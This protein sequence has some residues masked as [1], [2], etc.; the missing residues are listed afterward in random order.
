M[1]YNA[2][3]EKFWELAQK[4]YNSAMYTIVAIDDDPL[5]RSMLARILPP[6]GH[7]LAFAVDCASG[8]QACIQNKPDLILLDVM[9][10]DG[11]GVGLCRKIRSDPKLRHIPVLLLTGEAVTVENRVAG[12]EAGAEDYILKPFDPPDLIYRIKRILKDI[13]KH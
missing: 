4:K 8:F 7:E 10:P 12:L 6:E 5:I 1:T 2:S 13:R 9:L 11:S 3:G